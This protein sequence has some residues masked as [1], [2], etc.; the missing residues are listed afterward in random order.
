MLA[1]APMADPDSAP[2]APLPRPPPLAPGAYYR[3]VPY[4]AHLPLRDPAGI[5]LVVMHCTETPDLASARE[6]GERVLYPETGTGACGHY[7]IDRD[8]ALV[9]YVEPERTA[10]HVRGWNPRSIGVE[11]VNRGRWPHWYDSRHQTMDE[12][13]TEAQVVALV[14]LLAQLRGRFPALRF[15][16]GHE[17]LDTARVEA[18]D[19]PSLS[20]WRKRDPGPLFPWERVLAACGLARLRP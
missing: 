9:C 8:G 7:Y 4:I 19:D 2:S 12:P 18:S 15:I 17:D 3:P 11:L 5:D 20:V 6:F 1:S 10:N 16:A 13:Y 14:E